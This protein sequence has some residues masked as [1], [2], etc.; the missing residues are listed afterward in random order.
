MLAIDRASLFAI[1]AMALSFLRY[2]S[3]I[4]SIRRGDTKPHAF[5]WLLWGLVIGIGASAQIAVG[6]GPAAYALVFVAGTCVLIGVISLFISE[7]EFTLTDW[8][9][10]VACLCT[11]VVWHVTSDPILTLL[12]AISIEAMSCYPTLR[13]TYHAPATEPPVSYVFGGLR[14]L[15]VLLAVPEPTLAN[16]IYPIWL[17]LA[18]WGIAGFILLRRSS[19]GLPLV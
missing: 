14:Y 11:I 2:G 1:L 15:F 10:L 13:K 6:G 18:D 8:L 9:T 7:I 5:S 12:L 17:M 19:L 3:Y 4:L 16:T